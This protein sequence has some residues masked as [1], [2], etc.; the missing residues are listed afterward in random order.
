MLLSRIPVVTFFTKAFLI[1]LPPLSSSPRTFEAL[2]A[3][4]EVFASARSLFIAGGCG[5]FSFSSFFC[6]GYS[7]S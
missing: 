1:V 7:S 5:G 4:A 2:F 6:F 3:W